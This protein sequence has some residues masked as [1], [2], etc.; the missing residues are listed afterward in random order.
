MMGKIGFH[1][2]VVMIGTAVLTFFYISSVQGQKALEGVMNFNADWEFVKNADT[3][4]TQM[5]FSRGNTASINWEKISLPH[6]ANIEPLVTKKKQ[7]QGYCFY[8]K[9]FT[10]PPSFKDKHVALKFD[11]AM[12][13][14]EVYLNG[15]HINTHLGGYLPFYLN[16]TDKIKPGKENCVVIR[17]N[18]L[19]NP[20]VPPG[21]PLT[22][23]D[24]NY[25][26]GLYR[27]SYLIV[28]D[29]LHISDPVYLNQVAGGGILVTFGK[30]AGDSAIINIAVDVQ[31]DHM[32]PLKIFTRLSLQEVQGKAIASAETPSDS[33]KAS[34]HKVFKQI[35]KVSMPNLWSPDNPYLYRLVV[36]V[37]Y[38]DKIVDSDSIKIGLRTFSFDKDRGFMINGKE[39]KI[40]GTN[41]HQEYPY[42][43]NALSDN[44][45]YRDAWKIKQAGFN[46]VRTSHYP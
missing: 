33:V 19:D 5:L 25:Y 22:Q 10:I 11:A 21:K 43:G 32:K 8:R 23:L 16:I 39:L 7:W 3:A 17:L 29:K 1:R 18:N 24:F 42:I 12:Q 9:F 20:L 30:V 13:V 6:T 2:L 28:K 36:S 45:Q 44:A 40:R 4:I 15:T 46:F 27:N 37:V 34:G 35:L 41:R 14:A 38:G 31:N 26:S